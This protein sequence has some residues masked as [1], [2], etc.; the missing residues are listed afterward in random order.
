MALG[1]KAK[2]AKAHASHAGS[3]DLSLDHLIPRARKKY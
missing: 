2:L 1:D 3:L